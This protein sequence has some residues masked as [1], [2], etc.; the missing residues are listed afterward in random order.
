[1]TNK[2]ETAEK[3]IVK[4]AIKD[5][6]DAGCK[7]SV[8]DGDDDYFITNSTDAEAVLA[9]MFSMDTD[10]LYVTK[11]DGSNGTLLFVYGNDGYD[12]LADYSIALE[13]FMTLTK[14]AQDKHEKIICG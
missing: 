12:V 4:A 2:I 5:M 9:E 13:P 1:M 11:P 6:L 3:A 14:A 7:L 10:K 8:D